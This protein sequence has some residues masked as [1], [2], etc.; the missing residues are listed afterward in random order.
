MY[1]L[2]F[3]GQT[4]ANAQLDPGDGVRQRPVDELLGD[5]GLVGDDDLLPVPVHDSGGA[6]LDLGDCASQI[7]NGDGVAEP[8]RLLEQDD[9]AGDEVREDLLQTEAQ[10]HR[11][12]RHQPLG[13]G[14]VDAEHGEAGEGA[15]E[16][17]Q[18]L[19]DRG[20]GEAGAG[21]EAQ[22]LE[23]G[24]LHQPRQVAG[25]DHRQDEGEGGQ[26]Q[27][28][29]G[30]G[31][32]L[33]YASHLAAH[34]PHLDAAEEAERRVEIRPLHQ[35]QHG[36]AQHQQGAHQAEGL[37]ADGVQIQLRLLHHVRDLGAQVV[38]LSFPLGQDLGPLALGTIEGEAAAL[39]QHPAVR[40][41]V[42]EQAAEPSQQAQ[43]QLAQQDPGGIEVAEQGAQYRQQG[44]Q[45][46][47]VPD[48]VVQQVWLGHVGLAPGE[49]QLLP[50]EAGE[51]QQQPEG[52]DDEGQPAEGVVEGVLLITVGHALHEEA[53]DQHQQQGAE[54]APHLLD[55]LFLPA[56]MEDEDP[57]LQGEMAGHQQRQQQKPDLAKAAG[58]RH[59]EG[60]LPGAVQQAAHHQHHGGQRQG[61]EQGAHQ[62]PAGEAEL[63]LGHLADAGG[64]VVTVLHQM[65]SQLGPA[66]GKHQQTEPGQGQGHGVVLHDGPGQLQPVDGIEQ[67]AQG[68]GHTEQDGRGERAHIRHPE[69][70]AGADLAD[71]VDLAVLAAV[72]Q[73]EPGLLLNQGIRGVVEPGQQLSPGL[74]QVVEH[75]T[76]GPV[77]GDLIPAEQLVADLRGILEG[78]LLGLVL[79]FRH[80]RLDDVGLQFLQREVGR[81]IGQLAAQVFAVG[82][83]YLQP[84]Q[85]FAHRVDQIVQS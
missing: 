58:H 32:E 61:R 42:D 5:E 25:G 10:A 64:Y 3:L 16:D 22:V 11:E 23:Q 59:R 19:A 82:V 6:G 28:L 48:E 31:G 18:I 30:N 72:E 39:D 40:Q 54:L 34:L 83:A 80:A 33:L 8:D 36:E 35:Y 9:E 79:V 68:G 57:L 14:P 60:V 52:A 63:V 77:Q 75:G 7:A 70:V 27:I 21:G 38:I 12:R 66:P 67:Q 56:E 4:D 29:Q 50:V 76:L 17:H 85:L 53:R 84:L 41:I 43:L 81:Q 44:G 20:Q 46:Q 2:G 45:H 13:L 55:P 65:A 37:G 71:L 1:P 49:G 51:E 62:Q 24:E 26:H 15:D 74:E 73:L 47:A 69:Q 78:I